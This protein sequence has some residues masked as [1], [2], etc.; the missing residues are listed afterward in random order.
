MHAGMAGGHPIIC[1]PGRRP[2]HDLLVCARARE[3]VQEWRLLSELDAARDTRAVSLA[4]ALALA[5]GLAR[6]AGLNLGF[7]L[8]GGWVPG[9]PAGWLA[10]W[11]RRHMATA[12][13]P[14]LASMPA[15]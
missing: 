2:C 15:E 1:H 6:F 12:P 14:M 7:A 9:W 8:T 11:V 5:K 13:C 4:Y 10:G 3:R